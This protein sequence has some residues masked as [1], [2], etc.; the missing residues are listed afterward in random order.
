MPDFEK[1]Y[2]EWVELAAAAHKIE[3]EALA[4][5]K[6]A[7][8]KWGLN[9]DLLYIADNRSGLFADRLVQKYKELKQVEDKLEE[10]RK[11]FMRLLVR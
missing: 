6:A 3:D 10:A 4:I 5:P 9:L 11:K 2:N 1:A 8:E 7:S